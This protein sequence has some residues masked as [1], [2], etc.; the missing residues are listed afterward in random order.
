MQQ[1]EDKGVTTEPSAIFGDV[2]PPKTE[3]DDR[4]I[5]NPWSYTIVADMHMNLPIPDWCPPCITPLC[6]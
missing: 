5:E 6:L 4:E 1:L 3:F 2:E